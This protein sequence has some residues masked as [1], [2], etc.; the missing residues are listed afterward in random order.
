LILTPLKVKTQFTETLEKS[1]LNLSE[2]DIG[3]V[4]LLLLLS[5]SII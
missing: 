1:R 4:R 3:E 5:P 2:K